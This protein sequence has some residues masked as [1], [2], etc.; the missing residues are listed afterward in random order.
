MLW[1]TGFFLAAL[2]SFTLDK[3]DTVTQIVM[4]IGAAIVIGLLLWSILSGKLMMLEKIW[5]SFKRTI[6]FDHLEE[7]FLDIAQAARKARRFAMTNW[8]SSSLGSVLRR[9]ATG[10]PT[11]T[12][13]DIEGPQVNIQ[14]V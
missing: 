7:A 14:G 4:G 6:L 2:L 9:A 8:L 1:G 12:T 10:T 11:G 13:T 5:F 3:T